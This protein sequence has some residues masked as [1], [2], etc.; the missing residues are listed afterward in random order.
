MKHIAKLN[1]FTIY[2]KSRSKQANQLISGRKNDDKV[3]Q[4]RLNSLRLKIEPVGYVIKLT[5]AFLFPDPLFVMSRRIL[6]IAVCSLC[7]IWSTFYISRTY[8]LSHGQELYEE[9]YTGPAL[10]FIP[11]HF[12][13]VCEDLFHGTPEASFAMT[14]TFHRL[15]SGFQAAIDLTIKTSGPVNEGFTAQLSEEMKVLHYI[16]S[17]RVVR[18]ICETG[19]NSGHSSFNYLTAN[20]QV[21]V[22]SFDLGEHTYTRPMARYLNETFPGRLFVHFGDSTV[23]V[24]QFIREN[25]NFRCD[26]ILVDGGHTYEVAKADLDNLM[27]IASPDMNVIMF[28]DYP[29]DWGQ[30]F[31]KAWEEIILTGRIKEFMRCESSVAKKIFQRGFVLGT[32]LSRS[33]PG[34]PRQ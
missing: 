33:K 17:S 28:D 6:F 11:A 30:K 18:T 13:S 5:V 27:P 7:A 24:P 9:H 16:A 10:E 4:L 1:Q 32:V 2:K 34:N 22:H 19:F 29:T 3:E 20:D 15:S 25:P 12:N 21:I 26:F 8:L 23:T 31:G 14:D